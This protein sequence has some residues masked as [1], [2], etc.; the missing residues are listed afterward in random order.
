M[1]LSPQVTFCDLM[2]HHV[3]SVDLTA[4]QLTYLMRPI[5]ISCDLTKSQGTPSNLRQPHVTLAI[6]IGPQQPFCDLSLS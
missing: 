5:V 1:Y 3:T 2:K 6:I 4:P